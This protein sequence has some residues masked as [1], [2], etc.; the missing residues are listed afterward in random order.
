MRGYSQDVGDHTEGPHVGAVADGLEVDHLG[1]DKLWGP[2]EDLELFHRL[3]SA[4]QPK[5]DDLNSVPCLRQAQNVLRLKCLKLKEV[6][7]SKKQSG[8]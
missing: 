6:Q 5:V 3:K 4:S 2:E 1:S 7:S 8:Q